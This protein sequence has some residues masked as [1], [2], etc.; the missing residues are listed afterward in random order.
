MTRRWLAFAPIILMPLLLLS[1]RPQARPA[2]G[3]PPLPLVYLAA[4]SRESAF[5]R[6]ALMWLGKDGRKRR[7]TPYLPASKWFDTRVAPGG[8]T[9]A[10][11]KA[12][13]VYLVTLPGGALRVVQAPRDLYLTGT[14]GAGFAWHPAGELLA[15]ALHHK[16]KATSGVALVDARSARIKAYLQ[17]AR[18]HSYIIRAIA[19]SPKGDRLAVASTGGLSIWTV[20]GRQ[21]RRL[22]STS[23]EGR[24][25]ALRGEVV[26][27]ISWSPDGGTLAFC[28]FREPAGV[29]ELQVMR[30]DGSQRRRWGEHEGQPIVWSPDGRYLLHGRPPA[31][32]RDH[33]LT[34]LDLR[35]GKPVPPI[36]GI[37]SLWALDWSR[38]GNHM[39]AGQYTG[40]FQHRRYSTVML[41]FPSGR[42]VV[43]LPP[44][45][46]SGPGAWVD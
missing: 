46:T 1:C 23:M 37:A 36:D 39:L 21:Q 30:P 29:M 34:C 38:S 6:A 42:Q 2:I 8:R 26:C 16:R 10:F 4:R 41:D 18:T 43:L 17:S 5:D 28:V 22:I 7:L 14:A 11:E 3:K 40:D 32:R 9:V 19:W 31:G 45:Q 27:A 25:G 44:S 13:R 33:E 35:T 12:D 24:A 15:C 20:D